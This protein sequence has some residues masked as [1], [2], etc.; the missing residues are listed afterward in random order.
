MAIE[1]LNVDCT[2]REPFEVN[3]QITDPP[4]SAWVHANTVSSTPRD[5]VFDVRA[6]QYRYDPL[7]DGVARAVAAQ[8]AAVDGWSLVFTDTK[9]LHRW[10][11][12][13]ADAG[14]KWRNDLI[15]KRWSAP[16]PGNIKPPHCYEL[17]VGTS[18]VCNWYG[19][20]GFQ[21]FEAKCLRG[22]GKHDGQ[23]PLDLILEMLL[24]F[25]QPGDVGVDLCGGVGTTA[26]AAWLLDRG[27]TSL[28]VDPRTHDIARVRLYEAKH[29]RFSKGDYTRIAR[30]VIAHPEQH[31]RIVAK[32]NPRQFKTQFNAVGKEL[33]DLSRSLVRQTLTEDAMGDRRFEDLVRG[34]YDSK[35]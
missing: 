1:L 13:L 4:Y 21:G 8:A 25:T 30:F 23:K 32:L 34:L 31:D 5:D 9:S 19:P 7:S 14:A 3:F 33:L 10:H 22:D 24:Y 35:E 27:C 20:G 29:G 28:E 17:I 15:W 11:A 6:K 12:A 2:T 18:P 16:V 26:L